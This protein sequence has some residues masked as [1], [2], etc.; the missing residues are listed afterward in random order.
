MARAFVLAAPPGTVTLTSE[1]RARLN[2]LGY[3]Q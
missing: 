1:Q 2:A 3:L